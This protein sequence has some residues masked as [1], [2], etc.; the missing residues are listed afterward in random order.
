[1]N[2]AMESKVFKVRSNST[3]LRDTIPQ[4]VVE[5]LKLKHGDSLNWSIEARNGE[6]IA[7]VKKNL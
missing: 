6:I 4:G 7:I 5:G 2:S 3:S 1:M